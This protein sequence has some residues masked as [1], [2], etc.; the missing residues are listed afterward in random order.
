MELLKCKILVFSSKQTYKSTN[1]DKDMQVKQSINNGLILQIFQPIP[2]TIAI[3]TK[4]AKAAKIRSMESKWS[5][6]FGHEI[7]R[8]S[9]VL[10]VMTLF[11]N[12]LHESNA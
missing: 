4:E 9:Q 1:Q 2:A 5:G 8:D 10:T 7:H 12:Q 11:A 3:I 6:G